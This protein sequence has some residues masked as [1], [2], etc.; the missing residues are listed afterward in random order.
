MEN[1]KYLISPDIDSFNKFDPNLRIAVLASGDGSNFERLIDLSKSSKL[2]IEIAVLITNK[3]N[4]G[5]I[6]RAEK[7]NIP[8]NIINEKNYNSKYDFESEIIRNIDNRNIELIVMAGWMKG[9]SSRF[10]N[11]FKRRIINIHPSLLPSFKGKEAV[12]EAINYRSLITGCSVHYVEE[13]VDS[14]ELII[15]SALAIDNNDSEKSLLKKIHFLEHLILPHAVSIAGKKIR[16]QSKD[17]N[18]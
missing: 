4:A 5:C 3:P 11:N 16:N 1:I 6:K 17:K 13:K 8:I 15:Q 18:L 12:N 9:V 14:G 10:V 7:N 2:D